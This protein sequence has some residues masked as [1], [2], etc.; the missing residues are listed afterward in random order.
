M[1][2]LIIFL[3]QRF[4]NLIKLSQKFF[5]SINQTDKILFK[6]R[7]EQEKLCLYYMFSKQK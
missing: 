1:F 5:I 6:Q 7:N 4:Y 2:L 3:T